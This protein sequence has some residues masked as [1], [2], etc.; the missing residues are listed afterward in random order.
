M[1][2]RTSSVDGMSCG[3]CVNAITSEVTK[4]DSVTSVDVDLGAKTVTVAGD[5][6][7][8]AAIKDAIDEA[9]YTVVA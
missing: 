5:P 8:D 6:L 4:L 3:H 9:G 2:T 7:D 1:S